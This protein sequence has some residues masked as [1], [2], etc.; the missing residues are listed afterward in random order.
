MKR[1]IFIT[2]VLAL[3]LWG[4]SSESNDK[5][6]SDI[7]AMDTY[8]NMQVYGENADIALDKAEKEIYRL[9]K[10]FSVTD[11]SSEVYKI[12]NSQGKKIEI[13][14][15]VRSLIEFSENMRGKTNGCF[16]IRIY[17]ILKEWGFT[18]GEYKI[19]KISRIAELKELSENTAVLLEGNS[20]I[21]SENGEIDFGAVAKG[22]T[23]DRI[24]E[25]FKK[26][27]IESAIINLG[28]NVHA[29]GKKPDNL[30]WNVAVTDPFSPD[31]TLGIVRVS[32]KAVITS[33]DYQR[34]FA[35]NDGKKYCHIINPSTGYPAESGLV[36]VTVIGENG[37]I[38]DAL[39]TAFFV[40]GREK[41]EVYLK[42][43][44]EVSV[45]LVQTD[46]TLVISEEITD[47]FEN[48]SDYPIEVIE[49]EN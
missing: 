13:T 2:A 49:N 21:C 24:V 17:P 12:N 22:Y 35:G 38:C 46:G 39:S 29:F 44:S 4:C 5:K 32:D 41:T 14:E 15:D 34:Y 40:M 9:E 8:M 42:N 7:F 11:D 6:S 47:Y 31:K 36:S 19:P 48:H 45:L 20:V 16:D 37:L 43:Q 27:S 25:I 30:F 1:I 33:G 23:S 3:F 10:L 18:T 26:N 28:G